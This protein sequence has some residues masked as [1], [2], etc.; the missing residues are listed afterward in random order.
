M[1]QWQPD[2]V[3]PVVYINLTFLDCI[4]VESLT[5]KYDERCKKVGD[6]AS[7]LSM[8]EATFREIQVHL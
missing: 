4:Q 6:V 8:D 3:L 5:A 7:K 1:Q 2:V